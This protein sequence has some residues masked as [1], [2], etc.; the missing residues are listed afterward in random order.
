MVL[1][2][3][4]D[5]DFL[6]IGA[7][8]CATTWL[9]L[10]LSQS[11]DVFMP[12]P[13]LHF[14]SREYDRGIDW[15]LEQFEASNKVRFVGEKSNSYLTHPE[16]AKRIALHCPNSRLIVQ[17]RDPVARAYSDYCMLFRRGEVTRDIH[18]Y[19]DPSRAAG[20]RFLNDGRYAHH[21]SRFYDLISAD[22]ILLLAFESVETAPHE[23]IEQVATHIGLTDDLGSPVEDRVKD[24]TK[25]VVPPLLRAA[26]K[27]LRPILDPVRD[28]VPIETLRDAVAREV[29]YPEIPKDLEA[30]MIEFFRSDRELLMER[31][32]S[33][34]N[35]WV[36]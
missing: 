2:T 25:P 14:F 24:K 27:P 5:I 4:Q 18:Y 32:P 31:I 23:L 26:L 10:S 20:Q 33:I 34:N 29:Q 30:R 36:S 22:R 28:T 19:L 16:A 9:Q 13:E 6:I 21:L 11:P 8:K 17:L 12:G 1:R 3:G 7:A 15:Y 35:L